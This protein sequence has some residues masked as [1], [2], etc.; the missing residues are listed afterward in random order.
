MKVALLSVPGLSPFSPPLSL[1][2][3]AAYLTNNGVDV[4]VIDVSIEY[5][6][7]RLDP[8]RSA[9]CFHVSTETARRASTI[10]DMT[11]SDLSFRDRVARI[12]E[13]QQQ[14]LERLRAVWRPTGFLLNRTARDFCEV[15]DAVSDTLFFLS[16][17]LRTPSGSPHGNALSLNRPWVCGSFSLRGPD[18]FA[19]YCESVLIPM[20]RKS[21]PDLAGVSFSYAIQ[22][23]NGLTLIDEIVRNLK[24]PVVVGGSLFYY[25]SS[26]GANPDGGN[27]E[28]LQ[29]M[30]AFLRPFGVLGEG[31]KPFL[32]LCRRIENGQT[33]TDIPG[34]AWRRGEQVC[35]SKPSVPVDMVELPP[36]ELD[37]VPIGQ[38]YLSPIRMA[39]LMTSRGCYWNQ[40]SFCDH[41]GVIGSK[42]REMH[43]ER[44][45]RNLERYSQKYGIEF[46]LFCD[47]STSPRMLKGL[48]ELISSNQLA[49]L[50]G[51]MARFEKSLLT[52]I[53]ASAAAGCRFLAFGLESACQR[54]VHLMNKGFLV[55]DAEQVLL[56]CKRHNITVQLFTMFGF[57]TEKLSEAEETINFMERN[58]DR[59]GT[60][61]AVPWFFRDSS[62]IGRNPQ[63]FGLESQSASGT[64]E[65]S[66]F[67]L[68]EGISQEVA[69]ALIR[70]LGHNDRLKGKMIGNAQDDLRQ[71]E[72][73]IIRCLCDE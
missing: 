4:T 70:E 27:S 39:P 67:R 40:C 19:E 47:E 15:I 61:R 63:L 12:A 5:L 51:G 11:G 25:L 71:E 20:L 34:L 28:A 35:F 30:A 1:L 66:R 56:M 31:E 24:V 62:P 43:P 3:L 58:H 10:A 21:A 18:P 17:P 33:T 57:P 32:Q 55:E 50:Y 36:I 72:Y 41:A 46:V 68:R 16:L 7:Y 42:W 38:K 29:R 9:G 2:S 69:A 13:Q 44:V 52:L 49:I 23:K 59:F 6:H 37:Q 45:Y 22:A 8:D 14:I 65:G 54:I 48:G 60:F 73:H 53:N 26:A 64:D